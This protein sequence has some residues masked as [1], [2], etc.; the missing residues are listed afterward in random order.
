MVLA[1]G[2][3]PF[4]HRPLDRHRA[5]HGEQR[6][7]RAR[8]LEAAV[9]E[10]PVVADGDAQPGQRVGDREHDEVVP[11]QRSAPRQP[12]RDHERDRRHAED[13]RPHDA[14]ERL[15]LDRDHL[16]GAARRGGGAHDAAVLVGEPQERLD[17]RLDRFDVADLDVGGVAGQREDAVD[18]RRPAQEHEPAADLPRTHAGIDDGVHAGA[19]HERELAQIDTTSGACES[20]SLSVCSSWGGCRRPARRRRGPRQ[21]P[22]RLAP[23]AVEGG[24]ARARTTVVSGGSCGRGMVVLRGL[25]TSEVRSRCRPCGPTS[26][27]MPSNYL[28]YSARQSAANGCSRRSGDEG[29]PIGR[30]RGRRRGRSAQG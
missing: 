23:C 10:Q 3:D 21:H 18:V 2:G 28:R 7:H 9:G 16:R 1:V 27:W 29:P 30:S 22:G 26:R 13:D 24:R 11:V 8:G 25:R 20:G 6:P 12:S 19:V 4:D 17:G 5:E 14:L 15:V